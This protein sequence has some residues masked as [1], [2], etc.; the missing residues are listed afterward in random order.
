MIIGRLREIDEMREMISTILSY[1]HP[2]NWEERTTAIIEARL[3][4]YLIAG[5]ETQ[6][7]RDKL[8][9]H[10]T[11]EAYKVLHHSV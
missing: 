11:A 9:K 3:Q 1:E 2:Y 7:L 6:E 8:N 10:K 5:V 4:T